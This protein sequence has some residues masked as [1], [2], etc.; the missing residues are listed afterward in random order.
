MRQYTLLSIILVLLLTACH[1]RQ[2]QT[3][4][5]PERDTI[6]LMVMQIRKCARLNT[7]EYHL[8]KIITHHDNVRLKGQFLNHDYDVSLPMS[9]RK[10]AIPMDA[11]V[12]AYIDF[13]GFSEQNVVRQGNR[14]RLILPDPQVE[15]VST[16]I[17]H[18]NIRRRVSLVR[19]NFSDAELAAYERQGR[20]EIMN[21]ISSLGIDDMAKESATHLLV[22]IL[23]RLGFKAED[24]V[25]T[26]MKE[27]DRQRDVLKKGGF[28]EN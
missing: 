28:H 6:P 24:I 7:A 9:Q 12:K 23:Q 4:Q 25:I 2:A 13:S 5:Q 15:L 27:N 22:P 8:H 10:V 18:D 1:N 19:S 26:F 14:I 21:N 20:D 16:K 3:V 17:D 11:V